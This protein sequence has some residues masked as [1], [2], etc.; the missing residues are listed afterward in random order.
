[1]PL[2][3]EAKMKVDDLNEMRLRLQSARAQPAGLHLEINTFFDTPDESLRRADK[4]L[5]LRENRDA[6]KKTTDYIVTFKG[7]RQPGQLKTRPETEFTVD[8]PATAAEVFDS[9]GYKKLL[10]FQ[11]RR[12]SWLLLGCKVELDEL[13]YLGSFVEIEGP[14]PAKVMHVRKVLQLADQPIVT[15]SYASLL[16]NYLSEHKIK[17]SVV[18]FA[19]Q[20]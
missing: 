10:S 11:K 6:E 4:G 17:T 18:E 9:L 8:D 16:V 14:T 7:P 20:K 19:P 2:E 5:R 13:P 12:E 15:T 1:M 3:I